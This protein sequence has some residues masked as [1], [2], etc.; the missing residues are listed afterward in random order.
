L[1]VD[2]A[3]KRR[4][5]EETA[6]NGTIKNL[7]FRKDA[8]H[9]VSTR[10]FRFAFSAAALVASVVASFDD[11]LLLRLPLVLFFFAMVA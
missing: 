5:S 7:M 10:L 3:D 4:T 1:L 11:A 8:D 9:D 6:E 2:Q